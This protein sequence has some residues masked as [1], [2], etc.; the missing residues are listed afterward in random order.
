MAQLNKE[1]ISKDETLIGVEAD[2]SKQLEELNTLADN[3]NSMSPIFYSTRIYLT[4]VLN[5]Q[6]TF[7]PQA[8]QQ[9]MTNDFEVFSSE[10]F[11]DSE[12]VAH[13]NQ[14]TYEIA[15]QKMTETELPVLTEL[16]AEEFSTLKKQYNLIYSTPIK[17]VSYT[18]LTLPTKA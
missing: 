17:P 10:V 16:T 3:V 12:S 2:K 8:Y 11:E 14:M 15:S 6:A 1:I 5:G 13:W 18:H 4:S 7:S 9:A